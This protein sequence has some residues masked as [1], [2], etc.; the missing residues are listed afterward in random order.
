MCV[1]L[2]IHNLCVLPYI[3]KLVCVET[4]AVA[5]YSSSLHTYTYKCRQT[6][7]CV[8]MYVYTCMLGS[9][10]LMTTDG[11]IEARALQARQCVRMA[12]YIY[13]ILCIVLYYVIHMYMNVCSII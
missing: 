4:V 12:L 2:C 5:G 1:A 8:C 9:E 6:Y 7:M 3:Y 11:K 10:C 13:N